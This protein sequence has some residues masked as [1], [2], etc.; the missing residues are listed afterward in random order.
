MQEEGDPSKPSRAFT[1]A[2]N[3]SLSAAAEAVAYAGKAG[4]KALRAT[5]IMWRA[6]ALMWSFRHDDARR[7]AE[8]AKKIY[9]D[10]GDV[11]GQAQ[12]LLIIANSFNLT[13]Q[14][15]KSTEVA[16]ECMELAQSADD[17]VTAEAAKELIDVLT[18]KPVVQMQS[19]AEAGGDAKP[20]AAGAASG[21]A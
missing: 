1:E 2:K 17:Y 15:D 4:D 21:P 8:E 7:A 13:K 14:T 16:N 19:V 3:K 10:L 9:T 12:A 11:E 5:A 20:I 18:A 6:R